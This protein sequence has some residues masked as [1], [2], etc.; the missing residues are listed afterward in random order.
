[1]EISTSDKPIDEVEQCRQLLRQ[2]PDVLAL[3]SILYDLGIGKQRF[4]NNT[5]GQCSFYKTPKCLFAYYNDV[6][7]KKDTCCPEF[8]PDRHIPRDKLKKPRVVQKRVE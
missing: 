8:Y 6:I 7:T 2:I 4:P 1:M 3:G 5:C